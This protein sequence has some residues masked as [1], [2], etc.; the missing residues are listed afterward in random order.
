MLAQNE[1]FV[2][3]A[4]TF[5]IKLGLPPTTPVVLRFVHF[6]GANKETL[7]YILTIETGS[8]ELIS[9]FTSD[10][11]RSEIINNLSSLFN[12]LLILFYSENSTDTFYYLEPGQSTPQSI[13]SEQLRDIFSALDNE[14]TQNA[15]TG[16]QIN[17]ST[18]D[19]FQVWTRLYLSRACII[20][21]IDAFHASFDPRQSKRPIFYELK[22][23]KEDLRTWM[24]YTD[25]AANYSSLLTINKNLNGIFR[26]L[27]YHEHPTDVI[28]LHFIISSSRAEI[29]GRRM[30]VRPEDVVVYGL[31]EYYQSRR[32]R[33]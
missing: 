15:G 14:I 27:T 23:V 32:R 24:P 6:R 20:N 16:K 2:S 7:I 19:A 33:Q 8:G 31:G 13:T 22:R 26:T 30:L 12:P 21:D 11:K 5:A 1:A 29:A 18:N 10:A 17:R 9:N 3:G 4:R 25:D 28:A